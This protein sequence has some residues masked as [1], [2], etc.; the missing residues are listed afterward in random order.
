M[1]FPRWRSPSE[2][3][4]ENLLVLVVLV[5]GAAVIPL[6]ARRFGIPSAILEIIYGIVVFNVF[7]KEQP[8]W[9]SFLK[10]IGLIYLMF[11]AGME[12]DVRDMVRRGQF[13]WYVA[14][15]LLAFVITPLVFV[16]LGYPFYLGIVVSV[17]SAG[18]VIPVL[19]E[20][21]LIRT[22]MGR[23]TVGLTLTGEFLSILVLAGLNIYHLHGLTVA[24]ALSAVKL[25]ALFTLSVLFLKI[26]YL[27]AWWNPE[28]VERVMESEDPVEEGIRAVIFIAFSGALLAFGAGVEPILGSFMAGLIFSYV[29]KSKGRF[30]DKINAVGFGFFIPL[31]FIGVG[32]G[33][34][35]GLLGSAKGLTF[36][37]FLALM[38]LASHIYPVLV[39]LFKKTGWIEAVATSLLLSSPLAIMIVAGTLGVKTGL[40][41]R[42]MFDSVIL[43]AVISGLLYPS[44]FKPLGKLI[45]K[46]QAPPGAEEGETA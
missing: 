17:M 11:V 21:R 13:L 31:F 20:S 45:L 9:F 18:V 1:S 26:L 8:H 44:L 2:A 40:L 41:D 14:A 16:R 32:A 42:E 33:F 38:V 34:N 19:R 5:G 27:I 15:P 29:F 46:R 25:V 37:L 10:E 43:A 7:L 30:E 4:G 22:P 23:E 28:K 12:L 35:I 6:F 39:P 3:M 36:A 24:A